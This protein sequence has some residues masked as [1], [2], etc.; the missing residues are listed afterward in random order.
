MARPIALARG[1]A[2]GGQGVRTGEDMLVAV[3]EAKGIGNEEGVFGGD[4]HGSLRVAGKPAGAVRDNVRVVFDRARDL[5]EE[6]VDRDES[7]STNI[8]MRPLDLRVQVNRRRQMLVQQIDG[9]TANVLGQ[10][11]VRGLHGAFSLGLFAFDENIDHVRRF[12]LSR[13]GAASP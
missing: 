7:G 6:F 4:L 10:C 3:G 5:D 1:L 9:L 2:K 12:G 13:V 11:V 8:S